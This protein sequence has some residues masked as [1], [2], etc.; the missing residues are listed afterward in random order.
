MN[1]PPVLTT[2]GKLLT[3]QFLPPKSDSS[4]PTSTFTFRGVWKRAMQEASRDYL[5]R[6]HNE[7]PQVFTTS[8]I[9]Q[10]KFQ[11]ESFF[12][13]HLPPGH[14]SAITFILFYSTFAGQTTK[15]CLSAEGKNGSF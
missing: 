4:V 12:F 1:N 5:C 13:S 15:G 14:L 3:V 2:K 11:H 8:A 9:Y 7:R 6:G 10:T